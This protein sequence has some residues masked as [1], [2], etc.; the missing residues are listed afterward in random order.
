MLCIIG[1]A[2]Y[3]SSKAFN[4]TFCV[5]LEIAVF[6]LQLGAPYL[7]YFEMHCRWGNSKA[8]SYNLRDQI[9]TCGWS[10]LPELT[11]KNY[12]TFL[13]CLEEIKMVYKNHD[14]N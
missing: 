8:L 2:G 10:F 14:Y 1:I 13:L 6:V 7:F 11:V 12:L 5:N 4:S 9:Y 3:S